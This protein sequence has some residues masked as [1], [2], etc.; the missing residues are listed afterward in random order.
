VQVGENI[1]VWSNDVDDPFWI[2]LVTKCIHVIEECFGT[3][4]LKKEMRSFA[5]IG[6]IGYKKGVGPTP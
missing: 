4:P 2:M 6:M 1:V 3:T 5:N